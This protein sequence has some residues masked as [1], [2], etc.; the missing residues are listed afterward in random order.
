MEAA[1]RVADYVV[2]NR[3]RPRAP[4]AGIRLGPRWPRALP[5]RFAAQ[6]A[7]CRHVTCD[8]GRSLDLPYGIT[9]CARRWRPASSMNVDQTPAA[10]SPSPT[11]RTVAGH[12][13]YG[14]GSA[15]DPSSAAQLPLRDGCPLTFLTDRP[16]RHLDLE[17]VE[18]AEVTRGGDALSKRCG[19]DRSALGTTPTRRSPHSCDRKR[20]LHLRRYTGLFGAKPAASATGCT[21]DQSDGYR[22]SSRQRLTN[23]FVHATT[24]LETLNSAYGMD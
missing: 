11:A 4:S 15:R 21:T 10:P 22:D 5:C 14:A 12:P 6:A 20:R 23:A 2:V 1:F 8:V 16:D 3:I 7:A 9:N 19:A 24:D 13:H 17:S 18:R